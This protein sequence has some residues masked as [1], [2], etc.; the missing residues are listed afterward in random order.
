MAL[1]TRSWLFAPGHSERLLGK[2]FLAGADAVV[3]DLE[4]AVPAGLEA[5]ARRLVAGVLRERS[6]W[7]RI[8]R[9][10]TPEAS[11]D[12]EAVG[13]LAEGVRVPKVESAADVAWVAAR[14]PG[15]PLGCTIETARGVLAAP[16]IARAPGVAHL[17]FGAADLAAELHVEPGPE[18]LLHARSAVV[19][20]SSAAGIEAPVD[21]AYTGPDGEGLRE[22]ALHARALGFGAKSAVRPHQV[23]VI[24]EVFTPGEREVSWARD[25]LAAFEAAGGSAT[26]LPGGEM[27]DLPVAARARRILELVECR[28]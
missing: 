1:P 28:T 24:N 22:A 14:A 3:L 8:N 19:L 20:A 11:A 10:G 4:D 23:P 13:E 7:V 12:L 26:R 16:E 15:R 18:P 17:V 2:V 27:V 25:V 5:E 21:G 6:A 9:P